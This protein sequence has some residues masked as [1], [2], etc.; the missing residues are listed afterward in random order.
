MSTEKVKALKIVD[1]MLTGNSVPVIG[2]RS[3]LVE[4]LESMNSA[5]LGIVCI[6]DSDGCLKAVLTDGDIRRMLL[7]IQKPFSAFF[8]DDAIEHSVREPI[9]VDPAMKL[10]AA[11][12]LMEK[13]KIWDLPVVDENKKLVGLFHLHNAIKV[14]LDEK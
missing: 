1:V 11:V 14:L 12:E 3:I 8:G 10:K 5:H 13:K 2:I 6:V 9:S 7:K 4:A